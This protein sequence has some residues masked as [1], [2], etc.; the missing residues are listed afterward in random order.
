MPSTCSVVVADLDIVGVPVLEPKADAPLVVD[1][2]GVLAFSVAGEG[3]EPV[4][5]RH[6]QVLQSHSEVNILKL[7]NGTFPDIRRPAARLS[8]RVEIPCVAIRERLYHT[9]ERILSRDACQ[10]DLPHNYN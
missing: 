3:M 4:A 1:R 2:N 10:G 5:P 8:R 7:A 9:P 6:S